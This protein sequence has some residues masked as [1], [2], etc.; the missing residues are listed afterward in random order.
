MKKTGYQFTFWLIVAGYQF[1][2]L[3]YLADWRIFKGY[4]GSG[5]LGPPMGAGKTDET[6]FRLKFRPLLA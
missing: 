5:G 1:V 3:D 4:E 2:A 6:A